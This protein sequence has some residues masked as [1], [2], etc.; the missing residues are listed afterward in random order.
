MAFYFRFIEKPAL[1]LDDV[2]FDASINGIINWPGL[3][4][5]WMQAENIAENIRSGIF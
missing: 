1:A 2:D 5:G 3:W 4:M